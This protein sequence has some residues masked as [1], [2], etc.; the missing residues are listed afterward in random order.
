MKDLQDVCIVSK[1]TPSHG[2][3]LLSLKLFSERP[4]LLSDTCG[5][6]ACVINGKQ[7]GVTVASMVVKCRKS[8]NAKGVCA[9]WYPWP[10]T[11]LSSAW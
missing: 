5:R 3:L 7:I 1:W 10:P 11:L 8:R 4:R 6:A 2:R 9:H